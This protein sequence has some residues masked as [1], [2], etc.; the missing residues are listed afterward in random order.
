MIH[1]TD[2][3]GY[4]VERYV[5]NDYQ[6]TNVLQLGSHFNKKRSSMQIV[7]NFYVSKYK[8]SLIPTY[9]KDNF[10][11]MDYFFYLKWTIP[12]NFDSKFLLFLFLI[13]FV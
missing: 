8:K 2:I 10:S 6:G 12:F 1:L 7:S 3:I 13:R 4:P 11:H 5:F 9:V